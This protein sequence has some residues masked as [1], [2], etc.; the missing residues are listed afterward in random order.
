M[1]GSAR[2]A[3]ARCW[4][5]IAHVFTSQV[6]A[7]SRDGCRQRTAPFTAEDWYTLVAGNDAARVSVRCLFGDCCCDGPRASVHLRSDN[8]CG[9]EWAFNRPFPIATKFNRWRWRRGAV[10]GPRFGFNCF[11][12][13]SHKE[14]L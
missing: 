8:R 12:S 6:V 2:T 3:R 14:E 5:R 9:Y 4:V 13:E 1:G 10:R 7:N 11:I